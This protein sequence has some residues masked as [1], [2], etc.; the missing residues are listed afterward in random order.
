MSNCAI[1]PARAGSKGVPNKNIRTLCGHPIIAFSIITALE[2]K[3]IER[4]VVS[5]DCPKIA[6]ISKK[7]GAEVPF[8]RPAKFAQDLSPAIDYINHALLKLGEIDNYKPD[9]IILLLPTTPLRETQIIDQAIKT[10][11]SNSEATG[12]RSVQELAEPPQKMMALNDGYLTGFFPDD[13]RPEYFNLP[14]QTFPIAYHP[15]GYVE[16]IRRKT[17]DEDGTL[18]GPKVLGII[19]PF[20]VEI[21]MPEDLKY[22]EY[23]AQDYLHPLINKLSIRKF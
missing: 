8:L 3:K 2:C 1:I 19:T 16:I 13:P 21:D 9:Q 5:T 22:L 4:V 11:R 6:K 15:N 18:Y 7:Y 20:S 17:L 14:R 23:V 10:L 12:L